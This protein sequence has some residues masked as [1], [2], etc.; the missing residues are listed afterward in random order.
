MPRGDRELFKADCEDGFT[1]IANLI[2]EALAMVKLNSTQTGIC[3][4]LLRRTYGWNRSEDAVSLGD[5]AAACGTS[6]TYV[7]RQLADLLQK[8]IILRLSYEPGKTPVY[9]FCT[10]IAEWDKNCI[11]LRALAD[12]ARRGLYECAPEEAIEPSGQAGEGLSNQITLPGWGLSDQTSYG[13]SNRITL[14]LSDKTTRNQPEKQAGS[15]PAAGLK[16]ERKTIKEREV[17]TPDSLPYQL[18]ELLLKKIIEHL[19]GYKPPDLQKWA[20]SM[21]AILRLD[22]RPPDEVKQ[23]IIFAQADQF[24]RANILSTDKLRK[25]YDRLNIRRMERAGPSAAKYNR[26]QGSGYLDNDEYERFFQ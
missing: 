23:V 15:E 24:W 18:A 11:N 20:K 16:T 17:Y 13:L 22:K 7:S 5:F 21:E 25:H 26:R 2:L 6:R 10:N 12:N 14:G 4:F 3:L 9:T 1:R 8:K 19:P